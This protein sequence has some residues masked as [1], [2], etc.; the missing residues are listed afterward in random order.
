MTEPLYKLK[1]EFFKTLGHPARVRILELLSERDHTVAELLPEVGLES[2]NLSQQL[3]VLRRAGVVS[4]TKDGNTVI[5]SITS[6]LIAELMA[7]ARRV[8]T[9]GSG[10]VD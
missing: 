8:L 10:V 4:A 3:G 2:S 7:V 1:T 5:Y 6:P 9:Q